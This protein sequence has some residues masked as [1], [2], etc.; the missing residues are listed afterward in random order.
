VINLTITKLTKFD[1][2]GLITR[3]QDDDDKVMA[4]VN[5]YFNCG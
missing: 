5:Q 3:I 1:D 4:L 2:E